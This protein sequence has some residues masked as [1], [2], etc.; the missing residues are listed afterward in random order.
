[1]GI[2]ANALHHMVAD[3]LELLESVP[4]AQAACL[5]DA[6]LMAWA[7]TTVERYSKLLAEW[8]RFAEIRGGRWGSLPVEL[9]LSFADWL[10]E[11][12]C[13]VASSLKVLLIGVAGAVTAVSGSFLLAASLV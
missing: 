8:R 9:V 3:W 5:C 13:L 11:K 6:A 12:R 4:A 10:M 1:M 7:P 2:S